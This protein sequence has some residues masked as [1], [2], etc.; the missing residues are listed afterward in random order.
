MLNIALGTVFVL[1]GF[2]VYE[3]YALQCWACSSDIDR[4]CADIFNSTDL[5]RFGGGYYQG[6]QS[7][8]QYNPQPYD[9]YNQRPYDNRDSRNRDF[10]SRDPNGRDPYYD[11]RDRQGGQYNNNNRDYNRDYNGR[12]GNRDPYFDRDHRDPYNADPNN[13]NYNPS[14][15]R[16]YGRD[17]YN[18]Q[19][20]R[21]YDPN[22]PARDVG[23]QRVQAQAQLA[24]SQSG[25]RLVTCNEEEARLRRM[26]NVC[27]KKVQK[28]GDYQ[29]TY[30]RRC[31]M[32]PLEKPVGTCYDAVA[33]GISLDFCEYCE[34]DGCNSAPGM[35]FKG[36]F[37]PIILVVLW[38]FFM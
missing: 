27:I 16:D 3:A 6:Y 8:G 29:L 18:Q 13:R 34:Y 15:G 37:V 33:R 5:L 19:Q 31:E 30:I 20:G 38:Q 11:S 21:S 23:Y 25:P 28:I 36:I 9:P 17:Q 2:T 22:Y 24:A 10:N 4:S 26:R 12:D 1:F 35:K 14:S 32:I 7:G